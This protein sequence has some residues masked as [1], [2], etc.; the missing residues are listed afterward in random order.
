M[1]EISLV[2]DDFGINITMAYQHS[3]YDWY[4]TFVFIFDTIIRAEAPTREEM[5]GV[6]TG[7]IGG[8][9]YVC[10]WSILI[11]EQTETLSPHQQRVCDDY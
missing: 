4:P 11:R 10:R 3:G 2:S 8:F 6:G 1:K 7:I 5:L 9:G